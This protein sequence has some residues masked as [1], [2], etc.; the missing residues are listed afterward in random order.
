MTSA[1]LIINLAPTGMVPN[2]GQ[3]PHVPI[4]PAEIVAD[5]CGCIDLGVSM[6]HLHAR[7]PDGNPSTDR[8]IY[9]E[10]IAGIRSRH[11]DTVIVVTTSG[12]RV[13]DV[14][15]RADV[16]RLAGDV[17]PD[18]ASLTLGSMNFATEASVNPPATILRLAEIMRERGIKPE[19]EVFD[20]GMVNYARYMIDRGLLTP[21]YYFN[22]LLGNVGTAQASLLPLAAMLGELPSQSY[23]SLA[24]MGRF[25]AQA[26]ALGAV[27]GHGV[28][29]GL[30][31]NLWRDAQRTRLARNADLVQN[32]LGIA[33]ALGRPVATAAQTRA[34]LA[35]EPRA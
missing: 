13:G 35:L 7:E 11:P 34:W 25:Q 17:K 5:V 3:S 6:V 16:L 26:A 31:D 8:R 29:T 20:L 24:G 28:R 21:P 15:R 32:A 18:M 1:P 14:E 27:L 4:A 33:S 2:R 12:R 9:A 22:I 30:E 10:I 19:L 23:F